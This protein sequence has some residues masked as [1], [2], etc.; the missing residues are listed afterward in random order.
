MNPISAFL[1]ENIILIYF[2]YGLAFFA[3]GLALALA[4]RRTSEF[5]FVWA[6][7]PLAAFG[8][9]H[10]LHEWVEMFQ[11]IAGRIYGYSPTVTHEALRV[12]ILAL[13]FVMLT[14]FSVR[15]LAG[16]R[17]NPR[18]IYLPLAGLTVLWL[19]SVLAA[20]VTLRPVLA[21]L[22][23]MADVLS[24]YVLGIPG[25]L[26]GTWA[27]MT[28]QRTFREHALPQF[29]RDLVWCATALLLYGVI[30]QVFVRPTALPPSNIITNDLFLQWFGIP[31][32]LFRGIM[33]TV[34]TVFMVRALHAFELESQRRLAEANRAK[35]SAQ[36]AALE[37]ERRISHQMERLNEELRLT[38]R[39]LALLLELSNLLAAPSNLADKLHKVLETIIHSLTFPQAGLL[40]L[41][42]PGTATH[43]IP[44]ALGLAAEGAE[45]PYA[46]AVELAEQCLTK[47]R[48][49]CRHLD[50]QV[51]EFRLAEQERCRDYAS[52][53]LML[54]LPL[55]IRQRVIGS[56]V[57]C[58]LPIELLPVTL[59]PE[60]FKLMVGM[61]QQ[62]GLS[63]ENARLYQEAQEREV[64]LGE[65]LHQVVGAQEA[66]RQRIA[67]ELHDAT[68]QSL[69][70]IALGLRGV[71]NLLAQDTS[72]VSAQIRELKGFSTTALGE[73]RQIIADLRPSHLDDLGL[74]AALQW[75]TQEFA[76]RRDVQTEFV[77]EGQP[78]RLPPE[79][80]IVL[81]RLVQEALTN[82][83]KHAA[84]SQ[85]A[86]T[87]HFNS[88]QIRL[89]IRDNG[90]GF[91]PQAVLHDKPLQAGWGLVGMQERALLLG[92]WCQIDS[93]PGQGTTIH[94]TVPL[95]EEMA[96]GQN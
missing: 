26:L 14:A 2:L 28:Q 47:A 15:L 85:A 69:T 75:Y 32:Q 89:T 9:L 67:R 4:S 11:K 1:V 24:R 48:P 33:A 68:G 23:A 95:K 37:T 82:I 35:L 76:Q 29:G 54:G 92:G 21:E 66:E 91:D 7:R 39:E 5:I 18:R 93:R 22:V 64:L 81:F 80:E 61:A 74:V 58:R 30:G 16:E 96:H 36:S 77:L 73:L 31:V 20:A 84:A 90:R 83:A 12:L 87:L 42:D 3:L 62:L 78:A 60:E 46:L 41:V 27:L 13:S 6:I 79:Y 72:G 17:P 45:S 86:V 56:L 94:V 53:I 52:P 71:E 59:S 44:A 8:L 65:L 34:L 38:T 19:L 55:T 43:R 50:G 49:L 25:A 10:G 40:L 88:G 70:A 51:I 63:L 57:L